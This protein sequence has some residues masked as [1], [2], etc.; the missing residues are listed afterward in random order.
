MDNKNFMTVKL[1][2]LLFNVKSKY[3]ISYVFKLS[4]V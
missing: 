4:A 1:E 2:H 3:K